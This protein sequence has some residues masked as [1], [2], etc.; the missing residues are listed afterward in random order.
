MKTL[1]L[2]LLLTANAFAYTNGN[3]F[4]D[5]PEKASRIEGDAIAYRNLYWYEWP[6]LYFIR[7]MNFIMCQRR[8]IMEELKPKVCIK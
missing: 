8:R 1:I 4:S 6:Y 7:T 5:A 2:F 3:S